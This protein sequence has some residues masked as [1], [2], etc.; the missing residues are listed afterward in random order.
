[1]QKFKTQYIGEEDKLL[2]TELVIEGTPHTFMIDTG[3]TINIVH[4]KKIKPFVLSNKTSKIKGFNG[5][6]KASI[7]ESLTTDEGRIIKEALTADLTFL[8]KHIPNLK[9]VIGLNFL[10]DNNITFKFI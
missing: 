7:C 1:M 3:A 6:T 5:S 10:I 9:G 8:R 4:N 2:I